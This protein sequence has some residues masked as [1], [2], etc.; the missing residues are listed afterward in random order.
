MVWEDDTNYNGSGSDS[1]IFYKQ[2]NATSSTWT[3]TEVVSTESTDGSWYPHSAIDDIGN[4]HVVWDDNT[5]YNGSG[6][7]SD[8]FYKRWDTTSSTWTTTEV[9]STESTVASWYAHIAIDATGNLHVVWD[10]RTNYS[11]SGTDLDIFYKRWDTTSS[12]WTTT[13]VVST[14][15]TD[16]SDYP[17][18]SIDGTGNIHVVWDDRT[19]YNGSG[20][21]YDIFYKQLRILSSEIII[22]SPDQNAFFGNLAPNFDV[23]VMGSNINTTWY[24]LDEGATNITFSGLTGTIDQTE[25]DKLSNGQVTIRF[26]ANDSLGQNEF[27]EV[28]IWKDTISPQIMISSPTPNELCGITTPSFNIQIIEPNLQ[29]KYYSLN[30]RPN[31]TFTTETEFSQTEWDQIG[32]GTVLITFYA[33]DKVGNTNSSEYFVRKDAYTPVI[34][35]YSPLD[36]ESF[37]STAPNFSI[38]IIEEDLDSTWYTIEGVDGIFSVT[39]LTGTIDQ[40]E[41]DNTLEG[42]ITITFYAQ[43][44]AGNT[45]IESVTV[46][47]SIPSQPSVPGYNLFYLF[48][49]L[50]VVVII[51]SKKLKKF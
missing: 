38:S 6:S 41:W 4:I 30:G 26:Y 27:K 21:D 37:G 33:I 34:T 9:V 22:N 43:D 25:W 12:T 49:I 2:W 14:E 28:L 13:E 45:G 51:L 35:V 46:I 39:G 3:I 29:Q 16:E 36:E 5:N 40:T 42:Q 48:G 23:S 44:R 47:K 32:N 1:D 19:N 7:D 15:S 50:S 31:I 10:D 17:T 11:G 18:I 20:T 24:T 8:I